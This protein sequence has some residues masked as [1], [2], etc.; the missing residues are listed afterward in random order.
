MSFIVPE[1]YPILSAAAATTIGRVRTVNEDR[2]LI[3]PTNGWFAIADGIGGLPFG[4]RASECAIRH[5]AREIAR[6]NSD[7]RD[8]PGIVS[9]CHQ[10]VRQ[11][12]AFLAPR[13][14][15]GTT[16]TLLRF[17][18]KIYPQSALMA[19]I[20]DSVAYLHPARIHPL[21]RLSKDH[22]V[23]APPVHIEGFDCR[24]FQ[25]PSRLDRYVGQATLPECDIRR[26][27]VEPKDRLILCSDGLTRAVDEEDLADLSAVQ[28]SASELARA[29]VQIAD[30]RG[31]LDNATV[32]IIDVVS[33]QAKQH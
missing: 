7:T 16:L 30:I 18:T 6:P 29:L 33:T 12:G 9:S 2:Y 31:G 1:S 22:S 5:L 15:I 27:L 19:H 26:I 23:L 3:D 8:L 17:T 25:A 21:V 11:V 32:I 13:T 20:G 4:E 28:P 14:G 24:T 10:A